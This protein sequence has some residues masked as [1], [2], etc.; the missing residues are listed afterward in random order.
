[1][2]AITLSLGVTCNQGSVRLSGGSTTQGRVEICINNNWGTVCDDGWST[3]DANIVC[4]QLGY[5]NAGNRGENTLFVFS[6]NSFVHRC[7]CKI[8]CLL[9]P[10]IRF[11]TDDLCWLY[12]V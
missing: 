7:Y 10:R 4:R 9:W 12:W 3:V 6:E 2:I 8:K 11:H 5:S 1:M